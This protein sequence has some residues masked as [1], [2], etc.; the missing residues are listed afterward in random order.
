MLIFFHPPWNFVHF[1]AMVQSRVWFAWCRN[2]FQSKPKRSNRERKL[3]EVI[4]KKTGKKRRENPSRP[5][6]GKTKANQI[7]REQTSKRQSWERGSHPRKALAREDFPDPVAP[8]ITIRGSGSSGTRGLWLRAMGNKTR[9]KPPTATKP[10][11]GLDEYEPTL[12]PGYMCF[13]PEDV[14]AN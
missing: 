3:R 8:T 1:Q 5:W 2:R 12:I 11:L 13:Q 10:M 14:Y 9:R 6:R 7:K 4:K